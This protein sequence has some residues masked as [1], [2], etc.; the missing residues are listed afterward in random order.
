M[1]IGF[2]DL[3]QFCRQVDGTMVDRER[4][5]AISKIRL[6]I[7]N[8]RQIQSASHGSGTTTSCHAW[9][10]ELDL[11]ESRA[12]DRLNDHVVSR[13]NGINRIRRRCVATDDHGRGQDSGADHTASHNGALFKK[14]KIERSHSGI[15]P[16]AV[17]MRAAAQGLALAFKFVM[18]AVRRLV[19]G[20]L[21]TDLSIFV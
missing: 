16:D 1:V 9:Q 19:N 8:A 13:G 2:R 6:Q 5:L 20:G 7:S 10:L 18:A 17:V 3:I 4:A 11:L 12:A 15:V 21:P 14:I